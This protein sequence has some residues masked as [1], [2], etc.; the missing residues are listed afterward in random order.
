MLYEMGGLFL[1]CCVFPLL[2]AGQQVAVPAADLDRVQIGSSA[3]DFQ[4]PSA[5]GEALRLSS[6]R[7]KNVVLVFYRGHW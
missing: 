1:L 2:V 6:L 5:S 4:L 3:P 7:G